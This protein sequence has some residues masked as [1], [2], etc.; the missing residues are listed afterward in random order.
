MDIGDPRLVAADRLQ[1]FKLLIEPQLEVLYRSAHRLAGNRVDA[2]DLVQDTCLKAWQQLPAP[3]ADTT[4][5]RWLLRI[6]YHRFVDEARRRKRAP[7]QPLNGADDPTHRL[8]SASPGPEQLAETAESELALETA[9]QRL[10]RTQRMLLTLRAEG[11]GL[12]EIE[13]ITGISR[14]V[15]RARLHR[16]RRSLAR[17]LEDAE[18]TAA[19]ESPARRSR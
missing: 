18:G 11:Y 2:E 5:D 1:R 4:L 13:D 17:H 3:P 9:W 14:D 19:T 15:L 6:L 10:E 8:P 16:A 12:R 7:V